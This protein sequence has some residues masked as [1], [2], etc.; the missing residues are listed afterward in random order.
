MVMVSGKPRFSTINPASRAVLDRPNWYELTEPLSYGDIHLPI[1]FLTD[2]ASTPPFTWPIF[3]PR[4]KYDPASL[5]HD[6]LYKNS[7]GTRKE[8]DDIFLEC[9]ILLDVPVWKRRTMYRAVRLFGGGV[10]KKALK[11]N[12]TVGK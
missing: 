12:R 6:W 3:P 2:Y 4:G 1:G 11:K 5:V 8:A 9:M 10:W 7:I